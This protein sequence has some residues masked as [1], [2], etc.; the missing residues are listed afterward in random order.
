MTHPVAVIARAIHD[1]QRLER[2]AD[3]LHRRLVAYSL[4]DESV[5]AAQLA[6]DIA[7]RARVAAEALG[8]TP[9]KWRPRR[10]SVGADPIALGDRVTLRKD[11]AKRFG[12]MVGKRSIFT[13]VE[14]VGTNKMILELAGEKP[15]L[16]PVTRSNVVRIVEEKP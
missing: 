3:F 9:P 5:V 15:L 1:A 8:N 10:G 11:V 13:V 12:G 16:I 6:A 4:P 7:A 2:R 14:F